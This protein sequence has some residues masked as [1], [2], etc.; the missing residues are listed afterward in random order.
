MIEVMRLLMMLLAKRDE[1]MATECMVASL[2][3]WA[4]HR[5]MVSSLDLDL[6]LDLD[7]GTSLTYFDK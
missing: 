4:Y 5:D 1:W 6:D 3:G 7:R 2:V